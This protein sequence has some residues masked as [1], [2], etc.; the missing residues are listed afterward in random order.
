MAW[1]KDFFK[2]FKIKVTIKKLPKGYG[3]GLAFK[4]SVI[5]NSKY[6]REKN[7]DYYSIHLVCHEVCHILCRR[8]NKYKKAHEC[9]NSDYQ[10]RIGLKKELFCDRMADKMVK[11]LFPDLPLFKSYR[12][13]SNKKWYKEFYLDKY[14][15][16]GK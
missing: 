13:E 15:P 7:P 10:R 6:F 12:L 1:V 14:F 11:S 16:R 9:F 3:G 5:L 8:H 4:N 2:Q